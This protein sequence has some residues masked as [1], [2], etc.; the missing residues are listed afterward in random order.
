VPA[1]LDP[2]APSVA[3]DETGRRARQRYLLRRLA[4]LAWDYWPACLGLIALQ[5][6]LLLLAVAGLSGAGM[7]IDYLRQELEPG[8]PAPRWLC[9]WAPPATRSP[10]AILLSIGALIFLA[11]ALR[12]WLSYLNAVMGN[13]LGQGR[14]V[15][16][17]R[18]SVFRK[19]QQ[20]S[21]R[22]FDG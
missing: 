17:L 3:L 2:L 11:A 15:V 9:G 6:V 19:M 7:A 21:F 8:S 4:R 16:E 13:R 5:T 14:I 1:P 20:L 12:G 22:F 10:R 18:S